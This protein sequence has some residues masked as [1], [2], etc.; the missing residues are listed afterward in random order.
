M[1]N[2]TNKHGVVEKHERGSILATSAIGMLSIL[3]AGGGVDI[4]RFCLAKN[5][6]QNAADAAAL[7]GA[8]ALNTA[9]GGITKA[10]DRAVAS[11]NKY[12]FNHTGVTFPRA[13]V[14]FA[15]NL[16]GPYMSEASALGQAAKVGLVKVTTPASAIGVSFAPSVLGKTKNLRATATA[17][18]AG[19]APANI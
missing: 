19:L 7:A 1:R 4:S 15:V 3:L 16:D 9:P 10:A 6:L 14:E 8:S 12:D 2:R 11:M 5:E 13:N 18:S 17:E